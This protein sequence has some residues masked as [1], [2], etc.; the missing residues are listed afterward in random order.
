[1]SNANPTTRGIRWP[2]WTG[3][4]LVVVTFLAVVVL[5]GL[6]FHN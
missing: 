5:A 2:V 6:K 3:L 1:M 4:A